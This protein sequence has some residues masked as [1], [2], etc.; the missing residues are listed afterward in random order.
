MSKKVLAASHHG[1]GGGSPQQTL[2]LPKAK[3]FES[4]LSKHHQYIL[5]T[6]K[7]RI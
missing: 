2:S 4:Y 5:A 6:L 3:S 7:V 1:G